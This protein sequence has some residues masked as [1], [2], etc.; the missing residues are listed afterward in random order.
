MKL[1][2]DLVEKGCKAFFGYDEEFSFSRKY[3]DLFIECDA[4]IDIAIAEGNTASQAYIRAIQLY[5]KYIKEFDEKGLATQV[6]LLQYNRDHL[7]APD[8]DARW[9][10]PNAKLRQAG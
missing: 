1:G 2:A 4:E 6:A 3:G 7:C 9:G 5:N 8:R 10:D